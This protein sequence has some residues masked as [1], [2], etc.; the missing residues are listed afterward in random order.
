MKYFFEKFSAMSV[1]N[2]A[3]GY[4][5]F[6]LEN[7]VCEINPSDEIDQQIIKNYGG[8]PLEEKTPVIIKKVGKR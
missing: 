2:I 8:V 1:F 3:T 5:L 7:G 4:K 6:H